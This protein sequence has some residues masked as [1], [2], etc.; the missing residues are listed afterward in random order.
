MLKC[1]FTTSPI[2]PDPTR[3]FIV[4]VDAL[5]MGTRAV[6]SQRSVSD[7]KLRPCTLLTRK[8]TPSERYYDVGD[9]ELLAENVA[10]EELHHWLE[11]AA[12]PFFGWTDY[13]NLEYFKSVK[14]LNPCQARW[15]MFFSR[16]NFSATYQPGSKNVKPDAL[17][18]LFCS[19]EVPQ[20]IA[21][22][23]ALSM[24]GGFNWVIGNQVMEAL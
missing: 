8:L 3:Q 13:K 20:A 21:I 10:L 17:S 12:Q 22:F 14:R 4:G 9:S 23:P 2:L 16:F 5:D 24:V 6:L 19:P 1:L 15:T 7:N 11:G 18:R